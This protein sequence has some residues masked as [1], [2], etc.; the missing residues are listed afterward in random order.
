MPFAIYAMLA[1]WW[2]NSLVCWCKHLKIFTT[3]GK[4]MSTIFFKTIFH[5]SC[6]CYGNPTRKSSLWNKIN[7]SGLMMTMFANVVH[8]QLIAQCQFDVM[9]TTRWGWKDMSLL[10]WHMKRCNPLITIHVLSPPCMHIV[11]KVDP[12]MIQ[13]K[14]CLQMQCDTPKD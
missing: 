10:S 13:Y 12:P 3:R 1:H 14:G 7:S 2:K 11:K 5:L 4:N 6:D 8:H 9:K